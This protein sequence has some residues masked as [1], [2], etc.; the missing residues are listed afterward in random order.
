MITLNPLS[1]SQALAGFT[2]TAASSGGVIN[3]TTSVAGTGLFFYMVGAHSGNNADWLRASPSPSS[4]IVRRV[5]VIT[6][7][8]AVSNVLD[9][10]AGKYCEG[11]GFFHIGSKIFKL[12]SYSSNA[13]WSVTISQCGVS[14][15]NLVANKPNGSWLATLDTAQGTFSG[16]EPA[17]FNL[18]TGSFATT[19]AQSRAFISSATPVTF[20]LSGGLNTPESMVFRQHTAA[21]DRVVLGAYTASLDTWGRGMVKVSGGR[22]WTW[23]YLSRADAQYYLNFTAVS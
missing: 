15:D 21:T 22:I 11:L 10:G 20:A 4:K 8:T 2:F 16:T 7:S 12:R 1:L 18:T 14:N 17:S 13:D 19:L 3:L 9:V 6:A 23:D 5:P